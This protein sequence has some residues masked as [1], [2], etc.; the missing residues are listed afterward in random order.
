[1]R[2]GAHHC[3]EYPNIPPNAGGSF[4]SFLEKRRRGIQRSVDD[5]L[6]V[7]RL[8]ALC[9]FRMVPNL[10]MYMQPYKRLM[11][12]HMRENSADVRMIG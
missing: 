10:M 1:M 7:A 5:R 3:Q 2:W 8:L 9:I 11:S 6:T 12:A 4:L